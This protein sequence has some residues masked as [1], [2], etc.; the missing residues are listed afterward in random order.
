MPIRR[1]P[2]SSHARFQSE[3]LNDQESELNDDVAIAARARGES[4]VVH[5]IHGVHVRTWSSPGVESVHTSHRTGIPA[6][7]TTGHYGPFEAAM[8][9]GTRFQE[10]SAPPPSGRAQ[11][12]RKRSGQRRH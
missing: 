2:Q 5:A 12:P 7:L 3:P 1:P 8:H 6:P 11:P 4:L 9:V 10:P